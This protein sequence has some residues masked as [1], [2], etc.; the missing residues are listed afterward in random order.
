MFST[1][2]YCHSGLGRND[3]LEQFPVGR[4]LAFDQH[5]GRLWVIC[6]SCTN[7]NLSPLEERWETVEACERL[8]RATTV[9]VST[10]NIGLATLSEGLDL[11]RVGTPLRPE[12][13]AWRYGSRLR[14]RRLHLPEPAQAAGAIISTSAAVVV[15]SVAALAGVA[16]ELTSS[17][18]WQRQVLRPLELLESRLQYD[19]PV[20][21]VRTP[22]GV[23][24]P[25]RFSHMARLEL[26]AGDTASPWRLRVAHG[27]G[28]L[29]LDTAHA[30]QVASPLLA[31][32]NIRGGSR[33]QVTDATRRITEAGDAERYI[34]TS[35]L[36]RQQRRRKN[37]IFWDDN[38]GVLGLTPT[39]RLALEIAM[40]E[41]AE[42][43]AMQ[44]ELR[45]LEEAWRDAE[46]IAAIADAM[47]VD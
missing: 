15:G 13:A 43:Q 17:K 47:F 1:C 31:R 22:D 45:A 8:F 40:N 14:R 30:V 37:A 4:R 3:V 6:R 25:L 32:L 24:R 46:E 10:D 9:R 7:W 38:V 44:G 21:H 34:R 33:L 18:R 20:A 19:R 41:D 5:R 16:Y 28:I 42:R 35:A 36:M 26:I 29:D 11:V 2:L 23:L 27:D 12:F 39:E